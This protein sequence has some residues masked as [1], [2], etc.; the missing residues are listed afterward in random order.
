MSTTPEEIQQDI[1]AT[2][3]DI[4]ENLDAL[5]DKLSPRN[6]VK[7]GVSNLGEK[8]ADAKDT[9]MGSASE[10]TSAVGGRMAGAPEQ[11]RRRTAGNPLAVGLAAFAVGWM[12]G[13]LIPTSRAEQRAVS[14]VKENAGEIAQPIVDSAKDVAADV[15]ERAGEAI[16][17]V[18]EQAGGA[19]QE[20][21]GS[22]KSA[23]ETT[24]Q[25]MSTPS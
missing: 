13:S 8:V 5:Q 15:R 10:T 21:A 9:L 18:R 7:R 24:K 16:A 20:V 4:R 12:I 6:A 11:V 25:S 17:S 3:D 2:Q 1:E 22:A 19:A 23:A 14:S